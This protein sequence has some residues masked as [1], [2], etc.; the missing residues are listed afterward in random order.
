M[1]KLFILMMGVGLL[2][3]L[4]GCSGQ[5]VGE[6]SEKKSY[7]LKMS[8]SVGEATT[9]YK[10]ADHFAKEV[11]EQ[12]D[13][14]IKIKVYANEQLSAGDQT[15]GVEMLLKGATDLSYHSPIIYSAFDKRFGV[16]SAPF[17]FKDLNEVDEK[18]N[19]EGGEAISQILLENGVEPLGFGQNGF[20][21]V[22]NSVR[23]IQSPEDIQNLKIRIPGI[24]MYT[25]LWR[26]FGADP[27]A[28]TFSEVFAALQ[29]GTIDGQE[30]PI[31]VIKNTK[32]EEVQKYI[33]MW[34]YSYDPIMLGM[35]KEK[36][37]RMH[38]DDQQI[39]REAAQNANEY[40]IKLARE[41]EKEQIEYLKEAGMEF[42]YPT[43]EEMNAFIQASDHI[44]EKYEK[45][46]G[47]DLL[48]AFRGEP[49]GKGSR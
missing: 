36:F 12:T 38:P 18:L 34:N 49:E 25:D 32:L 41:L 42:H 14:R 5:P 31:D 27:T 11:E 13:G 9:W 15:K 48:Q 4:A 44:Y 33:T 29:Q 20:R 28:M 10:A 8:I 46:W 43:E 22:T 17:L 26:G 1:R 40:Q 3:A 7:N 30:N 6:A 21:Q 35:N 37:D 24:N 2:A 16:I 39:I 45:E 23:P 19:G 47:T